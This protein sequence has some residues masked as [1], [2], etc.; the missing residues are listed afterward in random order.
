MGL[1]RSAAWRISN[2]HFLNNPG[3]CETLPPSWFF[4]NLG[5]G[6][7][8]SRGPQPFGQISSS[9][10]CRGRPGRPKTSL[11][12]H[13]AAHYPCPLR[14]GAQSHN[15]ADDVKSVPTPVSLTP[16]EGDVTQTGKVNL[17][18]RLYF[19]KMEYNE[20]PLVTYFRRLEIL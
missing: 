10:S 18:P 3:T 7:P 8:K 9:P 19:T 2:T 4:I 6:L 15:R 1:T 14:T 11:A 16:E 20:R 12:K 17:Y 5:R 13:Y